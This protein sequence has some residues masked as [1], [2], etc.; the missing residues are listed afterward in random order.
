LASVVLAAA[1]I[2]VLAGGAMAAASGARRSSAAL[3]RFLI[4]CRTPDVTF[5]PSRGADLEA[6]DQ[7]P[8]IASA[9][10]VSFAELTVLDD[11]GN[12]DEA[13]F[14]ALL[15]FIRLPRAG[16]L[17]EVN[18]PRLI[19]GRE[20]DPTA[21]LEI[22]VNE[23]LARVRHLAL[24]ATLSVVAIA[25]DQA[26]IL[27]TGG[28]PHGPTL[29]LR[30][31]GIVREP[32]DVDPPASQ[33][34]AAVAFVTE[35]LELSPAFEDRY[36]NEIAHGDPPGG[37]AQSVR[38][39][40][41]LADLDAFR[42]AVAVISP[43]TAATIAPGSEADV[44]A[45][46]AR[47]AIAVETLS[48]IAL[49]IVLA[50]TATVLGGAALFRLARNAATDTATLRALGLTR[51]QR[52][53]VAF[54]S[55][56]AAVGAGLT[57]AIAVGVASSPL[58]PIGLARQAEIDPGVHADLTVLSAGT[59]LAALVLLTLAAAGAALAAADRP[60][61]PRA[62]Q[63][64]TRSAAFGAPLPVLLGLRFATGAGRRSRVTPLHIALTAGAAGFLTI[65]AAT[66]FTSSLEQLRTDFRAQ[67]WAWDLK[68]GDPFLSD[69]GAADAI[70]LDS[71]PDVAA[72]LPVSDPQAD[73]TINGNATGFAAIGS[74]HGVIGPAL[75]TG[76]LPNGP[77][78]VLLAHGTAAGLG[79]HD[80]DTIDAAN[81]STHLSFRIV[82][83]ALLN[84][85]LAAHVST[86]DGALI[87]F[88][89]AARLLGAPPRQ[90]AF[91]LTLTPGVNEAD[92]IERL[93]SRWGHVVE[94]PIVPDEITNLSRV[95]AAPE[96]LAALLAITALVMVAAALAA[97]GRDRRAD[98][99][100]LRAVG[101][102]PR[103]I[104]A[105]HAAHATILWATAVTTGTL[106]GAIAGR[107]AWRATANTLG[108]P[109]TPTT[110]SLAL[111]TAGAIA[112]L[113]LLGTVF[114]MRTPVRHSTHFESVEPQ[115]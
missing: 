63:L 69:Y 24:G 9:E 21:P 71:D 92:A 30:V 59:I 20:L 91:L 108:T 68:L 40:Q 29:Q 45:A 73:I 60:R 49:A 37:P 39:R 105:T 90:N 56:L 76:R 12:V 101:A 75:V 42:A 106:A 74:A 65:T 62:G 72:Y 35:R 86:G 96:T 2:G 5:T 87:T 99:H 44:A 14:G 67:G 111:L 1:V 78:E 100:T 102:T 107:Y 13:S 103:L 104:R 109:T 112:L 47:H 43:D 26:D 98:L 70:A 46:K 84:P 27:A 32:A 3:D 64:A 17:D 57:G 7:L 80:G 10:A 50:T 41:G 28:A 33:F 6:I 114:L 113:A 31:V 25:P 115:R 15:P 110:P 94:P 93:T 48:L 4:Y 77:G 23:E 58:T 88:D 54:A 34:G 66:V 38:L 55:P 8:E 97:T 18:R 51:R 83:T 61:S 95:R 89:D 53:G 79:V 11:R 22:V 36:G 81:G 19:A 16:A 52:I 85:A 82:G